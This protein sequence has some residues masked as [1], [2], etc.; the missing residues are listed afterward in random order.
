MAQCSP[1]AAC[2]AC[3]SFMAFVFGGILYYLSASFDADETFFNALTIEDPM[4]TY[5]NFNVS[6]K[7]FF[8]KPGDP[9]LVVWYKKSESE[10]CQATA[11]GIKASFLCAEEAC[12]NETDYTI[13]P[14]VVC[15]ERVNTQT[16]V[17]FMQAVSWAP[18]TATDGSLIEGNYTV[19]APVPIFLVAD[20]QNDFVAG[21]LG[22]AV[23]LFGGLI[24]VICGVCGLVCGCV[25][26]CMYTSA[27]SPPEA[28]PGVQ[29]EQPLQQPMPAYGQYGHHGQQGVQA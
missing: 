1:V 5:G 20:W 14:K 21:A 3:F 22:M 11:A 24:A 9:Q 25:G 7:G 2:C 13:T 8:N 6:A 10:D 29:M 12:D 23:Q 16:D 18:F 15:E 19:E 27:A 17:A 28:Q 26:L 4:S